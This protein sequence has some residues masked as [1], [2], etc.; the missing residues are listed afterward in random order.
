MSNIDL[1]NRHV[2]NNVVVVVS[3]CGSFDIKLNDMLLVKVK[4]KGYNCL[5]L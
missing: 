5:M 4:L 2:Y 3:G 1:Q